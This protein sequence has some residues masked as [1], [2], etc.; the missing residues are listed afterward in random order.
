MARIWFGTNR[1]PIEQGGAVVDFDGNFSAQGLQDLRFGVAEVQGGKVV[2]LSVLPGE[3]EVS[4]SAEV[5]ARVKEEM[6]GG[7]DTIIMIHGYATSFRQA[8]EGAQKTKEAYGALNPNIVLF[9]WPSDGRHAPHDY[10]N[11][12]HDAKASGLAFARG[13]M[14]LLDFLQQG[15]PCGRR[16]HLLAHSMGNYVL[17]NALQE[18]EKMVPGA[19]MPCVFDNILSMAADEDADALDCPEKWGRLAQLCR[20]L[21]IYINRYDKA[22][23]G[24]DLTK[25]N[26]ARMGNI[27]P[28]RPKDL[29]NGVTVIDVSGTDGLLDIVG[30][31]YYDTEKKVIADVL[32]VLAGIQPDKVTGR[33]WKDSQMRFAI[34]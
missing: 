10:G 30:H 29:P 14:K 2:S 28:A 5:F 4:A 8:I 25:G 9:S 12:R 13:L 26:P 1:N 33:V 19:T 32:Q 18:L 15:D 27:G 22:L 17:R 11:D 20:G 7:R 31:G 6:K 23:L 3:P 21:H 24:S 16:I 34:E